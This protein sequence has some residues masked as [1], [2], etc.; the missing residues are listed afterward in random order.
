MSR[1]RHLTRWI[2][3][4]LIVALAGTAW[5]FQ[6]S[7]WPTAERWLGKKTASP[8]EGGDSSSHGK[9]K[10]GGHG[11]S[12]AGH[13][14]AGHEE[15][16]SIDLSPQARKSMGL[17]TGKVVLDTFIRRM[18]VPG[19]VVERK[20]ITKSRVVAPL[21]GI[22]MRVHVIQGEAIKAGRALFDLRLTHED[23]VQAQVEFLKI[24]EELDVVNQE[25][26]RLQPSAGAIFPKSLLDRQYEQKKLLGSQLAHRESLLLHGLSTKQVDEILKTRTLRSDLTVFAPDPNAPKGKLEAGTSRPYVVEQVLVEPGRQVTAGDQLLALADY[27]ELYVEGNAFEQDAQWIADTV[28][29]SWK[30]TCLVENHSPAGTEIPDLPILYIS[31][32]IDSKTR[33]LHFYMPLA[34]EITRDAVVDGRR[35]INWRF[36]PGQRTRLRVPV[37][38]WPKR[39][40]LPT[41][42]V[43]QEGVESYVFQENGKH[44]DRRPVHV[45]YRDMSSVVI[46]QDGSLFP[47]DVIAMNG[48]AQLQMEIKNRA[49]GGIDPHAGHNH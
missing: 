35:F 20:G 14:H 49:G 25:I 10:E 27:S 5:A 7:W 24:S 4:G 9:E 19:M 28:R 39:I 41:D 48:A 45:E 37:E 44:F 26:A 43:V 23:L 2:V 12:H 29:K 6:N 38:Q 11:H 32:E 30:V 46:A 1:S 47:G 40:V 34:N 33:T 3:S 36:K 22:V 16:S 13:D 18:P 21:T 42:A 17:K 8:G 31:D 15:G